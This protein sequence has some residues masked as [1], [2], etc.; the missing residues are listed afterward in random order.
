MSTTAKVDFTQVVRLWLDNDHAL[1]LE[2]QDMTREARKDAFP[3]VAL[4]DALE[5]LVRDLAP[6]LTGLYADLLTHALVA[7]DWRELARDYLEEAD[8]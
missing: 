4:A 2:V 5:N 8:A 7:V 1:Y 3:G 6:E